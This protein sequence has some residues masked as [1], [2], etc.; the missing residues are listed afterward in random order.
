M[1]RLQAYLPISTRSTALVLLSLVFV[2]FTKVKSLGN[3]LKDRAQLY[4][5]PVPCFSLLH[6]GRDLH[7]MDGPRHTEVLL[8]CMSRDYATLNLEEGQENQSKEE[9]IL[10]LSSE[11]ASKQADDPD[12]SD[13]DG[14]LL[15]ILFTRSPARNA[16]K[17]SDIVKS[18]QAF[19]QGKS[20]SGANILQ[21]IG[22]AA[23]KVQKA[24]QRKWIKN[25][26]AAT[27]QRQRVTHLLG[28]EGRIAR[29]PAQAKDI[30][31]HAVKAMD[32][33]WRYTN[34]RDNARETMRQKGIEIENI[35]LVN[36]EMHKRM[37]N[38]VQP[39]P[40]P[41]LEATGSKRLEEHHELLA[42][43][44]VKLGG[45]QNPALQAK[46]QALQGTIPKDPQKK[47]TA[48]TT[49]P[50]WWTRGRGRVRGGGRFKRFY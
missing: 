9:E 4:P 22:E 47:T 30:Y 13:D 41:D 5:D 17:G 35:G 25:D 46:I 45:Y 15:P 49:P 8:S 10:E 20:S 42:Q 38:S 33:R 31:D 6:N 18:G 48:Y 50:P 37:K 3:I 29:G 14:T 16:Q 36:K 40:D 23:A 12:T 11:P 2:Q 32:R 43:H 27:A 24:A 44:V 19:F 34:R 7:G 28:K 21:G 26:D 39:L 1:T